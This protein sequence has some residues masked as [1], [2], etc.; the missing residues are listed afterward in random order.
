[1]NIHN[2]GRNLVSSCPT[3]IRLLQVPSLHTP[4]LNVFFGLCVTLLLVQICQNL[5]WH[6]HSWQVRDLD[7]WLSAY[8]IHGI[9][10]SLQ[11]GSVLLWLFCILCRY[12]LLGKNRIL[13]FLRH[14][15]C[16]FS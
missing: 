5:S 11:D 12:C 13:I 15:F 9:Y 7:Y 2:F 8:R 16:T 4:C 10:P 6:I 3:Q 14:R 1:M